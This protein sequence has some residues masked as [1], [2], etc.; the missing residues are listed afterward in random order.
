MSFFLKQSRFPLVI[1]IFS[2]KVSQSSD[3]LKVEENTIANWPLISLL[4]DTNDEQLLFGQDDLLSNI[5][6]FVDIPE[7]GVSWQTFGETG[8]DEYTMID[9]EGYE[10]LGVRPKFKEEVKELDGKEILIQGYMFPLEQSEKQS[11]FLLSPFPVSCPYHPHVSSNLTIE[12]YA[13]NPILHSYDA[14]N[15]KGKLELV[16]KDNLYNIFFRLRDSIMVP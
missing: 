13:K 10:W 15:I 7:G 12:V 1:L 11:L 2:I 14:I 4:S 9:K 5:E 6:D 3:L 8:M 16:Q